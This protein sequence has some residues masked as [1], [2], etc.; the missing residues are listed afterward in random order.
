MVERAQTQR[1][2]PPLPGAMG[3]LC[4]RIAQCSAFVPES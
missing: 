1:E 2:G 4:A 3:L